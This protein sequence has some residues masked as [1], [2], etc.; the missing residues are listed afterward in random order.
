[1]IAAVERRFFEAGVPA[2][3]AAVRVLVGLFGTVFLIVRTGYLLDVAVLP[4]TRFAPVGPLAFLDE[5][6]PVWSVKVAIAL[7][8]A[9]G[10]AFTAGWRF[11][12][13]APA[14]ALVLLALTTYD[15]SWQ[16][17]A[18]T[19][20]LLVLH[21]A[22]L[23]IAPSAAA[24]S[25]DARRRCAAVPA[26]AYG[27]PLRL[28]SLLTVATYVLAGWAKVRHGGMDWVTGDV[29][30]NQIAHDNL[31]KITL[32]DVHSPLGGWLVRHGWLFPPMALA[33]MVIELGAPLALVRGR[34][35][36]AWVT[37]AWL[38]HLGIL[39]LM[40]IMFAYPLSGVAFASLLHPERVP[41]WLRSHRK[42]TWPA[43]RTRRSGPT[44]G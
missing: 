34:V 40:A 41:A 8:I 10:A 27:W 11:R 26:A 15:N 2:R 43:L 31:R 42:V 16:H 39:A 4:P 21:T 9:L 25:L 38:F 23:A 33:S 5:P 19:E 13:T 18:H 3:L 24:W 44:V 20:N 14:Y 36:A 28:M 32:G 22:V 29:L 17:I 6:V 35:R 1:L 37:G 30:R 12:V 7:G